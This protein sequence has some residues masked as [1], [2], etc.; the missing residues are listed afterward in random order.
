MTDSDIPRQLPYNS[1]PAELQMPL[2][3]VASKRSI[4]ANAV[5]L[6]LGQYASRLLIFVFYVVLARLLGDEVAGEYAIATT[7]AGFVFVV[8]SFGLDRIVLREVSRRP[9]VVHQ[10][11][12]ASFR[13]QL[14]V[15]LCTLPIMLTLVSFLGYSEQA[16][17]TTWILMLWVPASALNLLVI[18]ALQG[19]E[20]MESSSIIHVASA[21]QLLLLGTVA[22]LLGGGLYGIA[23]VMIWERLSTALLG[24]MFIR[25]Y[26]SPQQVSGKVEASQMLSLLRRSVP[27]AAMLLFGVLYQRVDV[28]I[29]PRFVSISDVGQYSTAYHVLEGCLLL[30]GVIAGAAFPEMARTAKWVNGR[31]REVAGKSLQYS[32]AFAGLIIGGLLVGAAPAID[33]VFGSEFAFAAGILR[34]LIWGLA[35]QSINN[36]LG[37]CIIA[38][39]LEKCFVPMSFFALSSNVLLNLYLLPRIGVIGAAVA[40]LGSYAFSTS[41]HILVVWKYG[42][43]PDYRKSLLI[44]ASFGLSALI[45]GISRWL[46]MWYLG[47]VLGA[48][49]YVVCLFRLKVFSL[50]QIAAWHARL[51]YKLGRKSV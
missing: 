7:Y 45:A 29:M 13:G 8:V 41:M 35:F 24:I 27:F 20:R 49:T 28:L 17:R 16:A 18:S 12:L 46:Q 11:L 19:M 33:I 43:M 15:W 26:S 21:F 47:I 30:P 14:L 23:V 34:V 22:I 1:S 32:L 39:D 2:Q 10:V 48:L 50:Q 5:Y 40:T 9:E 44:V 42:I 25:Q 31:Y 3:A 38:A 36:T 37:R 51:A 6:F 4:S